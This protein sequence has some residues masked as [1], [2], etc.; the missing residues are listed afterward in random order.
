MNT[1]RYDKIWYEK[2]MEVNQCKI[3]YGVRSCID[4][5][6]RTCCATL[7]YAMQCYV[8]DLYAGTQ[9]LSYQIGGQG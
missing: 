4:T 1:I 9:L 6:N 5:G 8:N 3:V 2:I 7:C